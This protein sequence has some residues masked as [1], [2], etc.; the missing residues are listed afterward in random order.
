MSVHLIVNYSDSPDKECGLESFPLINKSLEMNDLL[1]WWMTPAERI[2]LI[3]LLEH[4]KPKVAIEIGTMHGGSLQVLSRFCDYVYSI[5]TDPGVVRRLEGKFTNV[6]YLTGRSDEVLP[7]LI[8][9]LNQ[10]HAQLS[11]AL[12]DGD[13]STDGVRKDI[14]NLL[15]FRPTTPFYIV[16]HDSFNPQCR[17]GLRRANWASNRCVHAVELDFITGIVASAPAFR[18]QL[19]GGL[20]LG[21]LL[22]HEREGRFEITARSERTHRAVMLSSRSTL[23]RVRNYAKRTLPGRAAAKAL[24][25][26]RSSSRSPI[27]TSHTAKSS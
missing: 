17:L 19:W 2:G 1:D 22:P 18:D 3:F 15:R 7:P 9:R 10:E 27:S 25:L 5:D 24:R 8:S 21:I 14:D 12:V 26:M 23:Q 4:L 16:M 6:E 11:F 13:H 20:A